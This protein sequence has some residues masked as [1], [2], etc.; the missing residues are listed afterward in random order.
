MK[1]QRQEFIGAHGHKLSARLDLPD[2]A[3]RAYALYAHCFTCGKDVLAARRVAEALT[4]HGIAV[5]RFAGEWT[6][7]DFGAC[8]LQRFHVARGD[9]A[10]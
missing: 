8:D 7:L 3:I 2:G 5:L 9:A 10:G 1:S 6:D 4:V